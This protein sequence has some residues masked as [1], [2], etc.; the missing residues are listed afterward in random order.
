MHTLMLE[1]ALTFLRAKNA[2]ATVVDIQEVLSF[3][4]LLDFLAFLHVAAGLNVLRF[5]Y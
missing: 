4:H 2:L 3:A 1:R 5:F